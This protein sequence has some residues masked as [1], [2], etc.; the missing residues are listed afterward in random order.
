[1]GSSVNERLLPLQHMNINGTIQG[2]LA[3]LTIDMAY[4]N[5]ST[6]CALETSYEFPLEQNTLFAKLTAEINGKTIEA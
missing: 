2:A 6:E 1:M 4:V 5:P 3:T